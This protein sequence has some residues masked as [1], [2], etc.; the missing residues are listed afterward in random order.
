VIGARAV[1]APASA[2]ASFVLKRPSLR[3]Q[4][5]T[6]ALLA[7]KTARSKLTYRLSTLLSLVASGFAYCVFLLVW[8]QV[9]RENP[10]QGPISRDQMLAYL[11]V[12]FLVNS[13]VT[14][15]L[16]F[17]FMQRVRM[18]LVTTDLLRPLGFMPFQLAQGVGDALVNLVFALPIGL[19]GGWF[20]GRAFL[21]PDWLAAF[22]GVTSLSLAFLVSFAISYLIVQATF[23]LQSGYGIL[24]ARAAL[25]QV[26]SGLAAPLV[27]FPEALHNVALY[28]P[29]RHT[30]ETPAL[31]WLGQVRASDLAGLLLEQA[32][33]AA[34]L[35]V[36]A[37]QLFNAVMRRH[38]VQGG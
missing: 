21:P 18:G 2:R 33:W 17:R 25:H 3:Q 10:Q 31:I 24:F 30:V 27:M 11:V 28:L 35:L 22:A 32:A 13:I 12:A 37:T 1:A 34:G 26:F 14:L 16:E 19:V 6:F 23:V 7:D 38:Q 5:F 15:T 9:Y 4:L 36:V 20:V 8:L 29:F